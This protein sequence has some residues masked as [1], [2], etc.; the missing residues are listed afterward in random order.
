MPH[1]DVSAIPSEEQ[2]EEGSAGLGVHH[3]AP[4]AGVGWLIRWV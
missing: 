2:I 1:D 4:V 3:F